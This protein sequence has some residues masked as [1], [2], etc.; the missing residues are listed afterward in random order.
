MA[1][2]EEILSK[3]REDM[4][5]K[6]VFGEPIEREGMTIIPVANVSGGGGG[7]GGHAEEGRDGFGVGYGVNAK[8]LGVYVIKNGDLS[9]QPS[10]DVN[11]VIF[12]GQLV[13]IAV[14]IMFG[15]VLKA[16]N[17]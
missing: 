14:V 15:L 4:N 16:R 9:W 10:I 13:A 5:V 1:N 17:R 7:G 12:V 6:R 3:A 8:P 2:V 11:R